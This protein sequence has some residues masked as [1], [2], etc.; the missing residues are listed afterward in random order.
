MSMILISKEKHLMKAVDQSNG[1]TAIIL[2][3]F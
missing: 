1:I 2:M 3:F